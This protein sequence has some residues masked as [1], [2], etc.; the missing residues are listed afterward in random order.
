MLTVKIATARCLLMVFTR[1]QPSGS[2]LY[3][4]QWI[5]KDDAVEKHFKP[6]RSDTN[7]TTEFNELGGSRGGGGGGGELILVTVEEQAGKSMSLAHYY[8][9]PSKA[10]PL[11]L[12]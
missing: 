12:L 6:L 11:H 4:L 5:C 2:H 1:S 8:S 7:T 10:N 3:S 9:C